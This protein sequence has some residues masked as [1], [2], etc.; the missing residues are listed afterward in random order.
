[1]LPS[2]ENHYVRFGI[3][4]TL[5]LSAV[6]LSYLS[7]PARHTHQYYRTLGGLPEATP[8]EC[9]YGSLP[10]HWVSSESE[11][12]KWQLLGSSCKLHNYLADYKQHHNDS[13]QDIGILLL[14]DSTD[15]YL[16]QFL[17]EYLQG[18]KVT[19][20]DPSDGLPAFNAY[21][22]HVCNTTARLQ[23]ASAYYPGVHPTGPFHMNVKQ[24]YTERFKTAARLWT[25][26]FKRPPDMVV[27]SSLLWDIA[28]LYSQAGARSAIASRCSTNCMQ[29]CRQLHAAPP[30]GPCSSA[31]ACMQRATCMQCAGGL[32]ATWCSS[33]NTC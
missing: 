29:L 12:A 22:F 11:G 10:G 2:I 13:L 5:L 25:R 20:F 33:C 30:S 26:Q 17:C 32:P 8:K 24:N 28:R 9:N 21:A 16:V 7:S 3:L 15:R 31:V 19:L 6:V 23:L 18:T 4:F 1:M 27:V 14:S